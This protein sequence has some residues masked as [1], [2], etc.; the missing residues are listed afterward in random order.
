MFLASE[1]NK[2]VY[3]F[4]VIVAA[5]L[6]LGVTF[7][8]LNGALREKTS[9]TKGIV[10]ICVSIFYSLLFLGAY[11]IDINNAIIYPERYYMYFIGSGILFM[12]TFGLPN[13]FSR[14]AKFV[15]LKE[16]KKMVYTYKEKEEHLYVV[17]KSQS[18]VF[19]NKDLC[20]ID[21]RLKRN[22]FTEDALSKVLD[23][24]KAVPLY[25]VERIG[26]VTVK[27]DHKDLVYY[28]Y[29][30]DVLELSKKDLEAVDVYELVNIDIPETDKYIIFN[31]L[32][33]EE[34]DKII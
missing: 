4:Y 1:V 29:L 13:I 27:G 21:L 32:R 5:I 12:L 30:I 9:K 10:Y 20:G 11:I 7:L 28:C 24:Y 33:G 22:E 16:N 8:I 31:C 25:D 34:F 6:I 19:L 23:E 18:K 3:D 2:Y 26:M 14:K 17:F 15:P